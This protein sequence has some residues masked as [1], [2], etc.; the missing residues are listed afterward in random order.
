MT[1]MLK[2]SERRPDPDHA[3]A[4]AAL[5]SQD[6]LRRKQARFNRRKQEAERFA[7]RRQLIAGDAR[8]RGNLPHDSLEQ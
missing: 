8:S 5:A 4:D 6:R 1:H 7:R 2:Y 3:E